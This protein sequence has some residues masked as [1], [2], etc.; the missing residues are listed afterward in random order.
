MTCT[1]P[2]VHLNAGNYESVGRNWNPGCPQHGVR[3]PWYRSP[4]QVD[5]RRRQRDSLIRIQRLAS[6]RRKT[7]WSSKAPV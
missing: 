2:E 1:C 5:L 6:W 7:G 4:E 3:S